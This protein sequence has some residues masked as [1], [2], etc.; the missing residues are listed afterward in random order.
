MTYNGTIEMII[1]VECE[2]IDYLSVLLIF[3]LTE[4]Q[5]TWQNNQYIDEWMVL[6]LGFASNSKF[7]Q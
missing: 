6:F 2:N 3:D 4:I 7:K 5:F 1:G